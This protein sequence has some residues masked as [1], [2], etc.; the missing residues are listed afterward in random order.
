M[1]WP[2]SYTDTSESVMQN[3]LGTRILLTYLALYLAFV[4]LITAAAVLS[5]QQLSE[6]ADSLPRYRLLAQL[7]CD[8]TMIL[9]SL[10]IQIGVY[11]AAPLVVAGSYS[12]CAIMVLFDSALMTIAGEGIA[13]TLA[14]SA[15][16]VAV[17]YL[18]YS[19]MTYLAARNVVLG[20][21]GKSLA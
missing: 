5:V 13:S 10:C 17:V 4:F 1:A 15:V 18:L 2:V 9:R 6:V 21:A 8:K 16:A 12:A 20:G 3:S 11:F 14:F 19:V 7:G